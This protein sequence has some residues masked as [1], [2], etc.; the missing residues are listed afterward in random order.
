M[1]II[2]STHSLD[3]QSGLALPTG[4]VL[5]YQTRLDKTLKELQDRVKEQKAALEKLQESNA[6]P[7]SEPSQDPHRRLQQLRVFK[8]AFQPLSPKEPYLPSPDSPL[9]ALLAHRQILQSVADG[10]AGVAS[11]ES[12]IKDAQRRLEKERADL[13]DAKAINKALDERIQSLRAE[14]DERTQKSPLQAA[15]DMIRE[16]RKRKKRYEKDSGNLVKAFDAFIDDTLAPMLAA[17][18]LGG[19]VVGEMTEV[20]DDDLGHGFSSQ[21]KVKKGRGSVSG[22]KRQ[23]RID[24]IWGPAPQEGSFMVDRNEWTEQK[25]AGV[26]MRDLTEKCLNKLVAVEAGESD[27]Y[28]QLERESA[29]ARFLVR[30]KVAQFHP[31]DSS[32]L[33][34]ID[35]GKELD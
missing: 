8:T 5:A 29:A 20:D 21:G 22:D 18:E 6:T 15:R 2:P 17:E 10:K 30:S 31:R 19:P 24:Q 3:L 14:I 4:D 16:L 34:L 33:R 11:V 32:R 9:P 23:R 28:V 12:D 27:A 25:A 13:F 26:E 35:F 1:T 7:D